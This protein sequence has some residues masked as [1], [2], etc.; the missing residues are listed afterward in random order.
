[1]QVASAGRIVILSLHQPSEAMFDQLDRAFLMARGRVVYS[2]EP[3][4]AP[5]YFYRAGLSCP[6]RTAI[7]EHMLACVSDPVLLSAL[8]KHVDA[9]GPY[10]GRAA[11][12]ALL[13]LY[14]AYLM[15][16]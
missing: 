16:L 1:M 13:M 12:W 2:G 15:L 3:D 4:A 14:V 8:M 10:Y 9:N 5:T 11:V 7:A 6:E